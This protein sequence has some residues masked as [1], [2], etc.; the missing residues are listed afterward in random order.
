M[1]TS[2]EISVVSEN[3]C[4]RHELIAQ[5]GQILL[6]KINGESHLLDVGYHASWLLHN[7][8]YMNISLNEIKSITLSHKHTDHSGG[9]AELLPELNNIPVFGIGNMAIPDI[10]V[11]TEKYRYFPE[12]AYNLAVPAK[13]V[14]EI[15]SYSKYVEV[16]EPVEFLPNVW[17]TGPLGSGIPE[18]S[19]V[20]DLKE[21]G[22]VLVVGCLHQGFDALWSKAQEITGN[23]KLFGYIGGL[24]LK[25]ATLEV[26][27]STIAKLVVLSPEFIAPSHCTGVEATRTLQTALGKKCFVS[28]TGSV[29]TGNIVSILPELAFHA[30]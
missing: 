24:H 15:T 18:Q 10:K 20:V 17:I 23:T 19:I 30:V 1:I 11:H 12:N 3:T 16:I 4:L 8:K 27:N 25:E 14:K 2:L 5:H 21:K 13:Q 26:M 22:L 9:L 7:F 29:G 28:S 6:L